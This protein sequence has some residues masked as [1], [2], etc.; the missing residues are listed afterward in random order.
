MY[1]DPLNKNLRSVLAGW[2]EISRKLMI[3]RVKILKKY[4]KIGRQTLSISKFLSCILIIWYLIDFLTEN[5]ILREKKVKIYA[6]FLSL[7]ALQ[8]TKKG[9]KRVRVGESV[10]FLKS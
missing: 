4:R 7:F 10:I 1:Y 8:R 9:Q 6:L 2:V 3:L 5:P